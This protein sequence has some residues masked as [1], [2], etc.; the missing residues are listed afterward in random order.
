VRF[1]SAA[2]IDPD[3]RIDS[4]KNW[5]F[6]L[7]KSTAITELVKLQ[8]TAEF[9]NIFNRARF[10]APN[11]TAGDPLMGLVFTQSNQPRAVQF[12][13]RFDF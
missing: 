13:L 9:Y 7:A 11:N 4:L 2:R 3:V 6:S 10:G 1:G 8:F 12:G 5:D